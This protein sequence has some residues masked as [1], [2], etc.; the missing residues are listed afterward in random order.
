MFF[1]FYIMS[2]HITSPNYDQNDLR[3]V[4]SPINI[5][6]VPGAP[7]KT[8][9]LIKV[10]GPLPH[11]TRVKVDPGLPYDQLGGHRSIRM[12]SVEQ[13]GD[14]QQPARL[15]CPIKEAVD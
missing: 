4:N 5:Y 10:G 15:V 7:L 11:C 2:L 8:K 12:A 1:T 3:C 6:S 14:L 9:N 13:L